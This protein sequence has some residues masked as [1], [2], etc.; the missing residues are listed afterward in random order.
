MVASMEGAPRF[1][2]RA[3]VQTTNYI[4]NGEHEKPWGSH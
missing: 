2:I 3:Q 1:A 4:G